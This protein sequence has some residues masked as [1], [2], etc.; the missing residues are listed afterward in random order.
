METFDI[1]LQSGRDM[2]VGVTPFIIGLLTPYNSITVEGR[3]FFI[4]EAL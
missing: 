2:A 3:E 1:S 4:L